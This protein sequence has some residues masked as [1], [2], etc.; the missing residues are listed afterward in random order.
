MLTAAFT[1]P[2]GA[3]DP[4]PSIAASV[5]SITFGDPVVLSGSLQGGDG[6]SAGRGVQLEWQGAGQATWE[7]RATATTGPD[8]SFAFTDAPASTGGYRVTLPA[9]DACDA[10]VSSVVTVR[11]RVRVD[12]SLLATSLVAG[13]CL[14]LSVTV[15]PSK[16]GQQ[17]EVQR[18]TP[19]GWQ[20][21]ETLTLGSDSSVSAEPCFGFDDLGVVRLRVRW[22]AQDPTN[23]TG[24][25]PNLAFRLDEAGWMRRIDRLIAGRSVSVSVRLDGMTLFRRAAD[26][27]RI[28]A[29]NEKLLL[30]MALL[31]GLGADHRIPTIAASAAD[32]DGVIPGNL[33]ILGRGDPEVRGARM[34]A[35][36][37]RLAEAGLTRV[38][39]R[40]MG[41]LTYFRHDWWAPGWRP[42]ITR[43]YV[44]PPTALT[45][46]LNRTRAGYTRSPERRAAEALTRRLRA[47][48]VR[49]GGKPGTGSPPTGLAPVASIRSR[50]LR[51][52]LARMD[53]PSD[54]F[55]A[56]VL[57]KL[58]AVTVDGPP[59]TIAKG[60]RG[61]QTWVAEHGEDFSLHDASGL[62]Y[63][64]RVTA[65]G[66]ARLLEVADR[67]A[68]GATLR[69]ALASGGQGTLEDRLHD[70]RVRAKTGTLNDV[71]ALS[72]WV[73][74]TRDR[75]WA[76]FSI[77]SSVPKWTAV[78]IE[79]G[80][81]R[82]LAGR[83]G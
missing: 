53:R 11:V 5:P 1:T 13:S 22:P 58:L 40:V 30:S 10:L 38:R 56:E 48:G 37:R 68:W 74:L 46:D 33:W 55:Y 66:I 18:R 15:E 12:A 72:G 32:R 16:P 80:I 81:V 77:L 4:V 57:G 70:V 47:L 61:L 67:A 71:S 49:V 3:A 82:I 24:T 73:W 42:G 17:V 19:S 21:L 59:G 65:A 28:P 27:P 39:G 9:V 54:N 31:D 62:S 64:N 75:G 29:S 76:E 51:Q 44:A 45:F 36:A 83:A 69:R 60:A 79:D 63:D 52:L 7:P 8:G 2:A 41:S 25:S 20:V 35:L 78:R 34:A 14:S 26:A 23:A 6:C 50:P 43:R